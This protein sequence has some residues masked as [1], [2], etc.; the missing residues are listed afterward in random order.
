MGN[1]L[2]NHHS[3]SANSLFS[4]SII[5]TQTAVIN[6]GNFKTVFSSINQSILDLYHI[7]LIRVYGTYNITLENSGNYHDDFLIGLSNSNFI[8]NHDSLFLSLTNNTPD[9]SSITLSGDFDSIQ[10]CQYRYLIPDKYIFSIPTA[11]VSGKDYDNSRS[12]YATSG[13]ASIT[14]VVYGASIIL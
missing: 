12:R 5:S 10:T 13:N 4:W 9:T 6:T 14:R 8:S 7:I 2:V 11:V 1:A 3:K